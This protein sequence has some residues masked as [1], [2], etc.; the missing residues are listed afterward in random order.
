M[1]NIPRLVKLFGYLKRLLKIYN[2]LKIR[3]S[4]VTYLGNHACNH[5]LYTYIS[6]TVN[7]HQHW[8]HRRKVI[9]CKD[10]QMEVCKI[11]I[12]NTR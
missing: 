7:S 11:S 4:S 2:W 10:I 3:P 8:L 9:A 12:C 6:K 1:V 5:N